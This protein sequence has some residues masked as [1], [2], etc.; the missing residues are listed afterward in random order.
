MSPDAFGE[1]LVNAYA[2]SVSGVNDF[3]CGDPKQL[4]PGQ[5]R[6]ADHRPRH[7][8]PVPRRRDL[9]NWTLTFEG[10]TASGASTVLRW[11]DI[12]AM[13]SHEVTADLHCASHA[14]MGGLTWAGVSAADLVSV[15]PPA[16]DAS[17]AMVYA[18]Y[19]Y[20]A[21]VL[22]ED[23]VSPRTVFATHL[24]GRELTPEHGWPMRLVIPHLYGWK[25]PKWVMTVVYHRSPQRGFWEQHGYHFTGNAW[26]EERYAYQE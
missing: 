22:V 18:A 14:S 25:G 3:D 13:P 20:H 9:S 1:P 12:V 4:P 8:G 23:L 7:Y 11:P 10:A 2:Q 5:R 19:G 6:Q 26:R 21:N 15:A 16:D 17:Y 24:N